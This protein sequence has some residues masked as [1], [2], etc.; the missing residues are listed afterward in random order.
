MTHL[1]LDGPLHH[2]VHKEEITRA[3]AVGWNCVVGG[4]L[5]F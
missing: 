4:G 2:D 3:G 5:Q 1:P